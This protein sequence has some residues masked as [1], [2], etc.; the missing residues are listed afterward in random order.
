MK[1]ID[2]LEISSLAKLSLNQ[3]EQLKA[4]EEI[5]SFTE[6]VRTLEAY[7]EKTDTAYVIP[8][9]QPL[10]DDRVCSTDVNVFDGYVTVPLTVG[11]NE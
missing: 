10:R 8:P 9:S 5:I 7:C 1:E 4:K 2:I 6:Y 11:G 3:D